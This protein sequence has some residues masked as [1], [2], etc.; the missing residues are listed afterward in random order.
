MKN[1]NYLRSFLERWNSDGADQSA[2]SEEL[3]RHCEA[4][5]WA[6]KD[7]AD[8]LAEAEAEFY[9]HGPN[10][11]L[12]IMVVDT[13]ELATMLAALRFFQR[14]GSDLTEPE[15]DIATNGGEVAALSIEEIDVLCERLNVA[16]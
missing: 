4:N 3:R 9:E 15:N 10:A 16:A 13:R 14:T 5:G 12:R 6:F 11:T 1:I 2:L 7:A 8:L